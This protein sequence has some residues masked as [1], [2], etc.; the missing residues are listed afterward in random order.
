M[1]VKLGELDRWRNIENNSPS[2]LLEL[3]LMTVK[4]SLIGIMKVFIEIVQDI[5]KD[6]QWTNINLQ[7]EKVVP[8]PFFKNLEDEYEY[9][10]ANFQSKELITKEDIQKFL[11]NPARDFHV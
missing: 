10:K 1:L 6:F 8:F 11:V 7:D 9:V 5:Q 4:Q 3:K 2:G